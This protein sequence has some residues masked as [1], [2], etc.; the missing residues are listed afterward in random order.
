MEVNSLLGNLLDNG[1][2]AVAA[3][4]GARRSVRLEI[5]R[6]PGEYLFAVANTG[7]P[8]P[9]EIR[10]RIY[11][12]HYSTKKSNQGLGLTIVREIVDK[13]SGRVTIEHTGNETIFFGIYTG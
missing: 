3:Y 6:E 10:D 9:S 11:E 5:T 1:I 7:D 4:A 8:I 2:E 13:Y 12:P